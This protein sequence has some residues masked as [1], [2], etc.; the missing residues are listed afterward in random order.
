MRTTTRF[1]GRLREEAKRAAASD[2][3]TLSALIERG[4]RLVLARKPPTPERNRVTLPVSRAQGGL[5]P[6]VD[7]NNS[8]SLY[9]LTDGRRCPS[10]FT[11]WQRYD[12]RR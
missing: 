7:L 12:L 9:D 8:A 4:L 3:E 11:E 6:G 5:L 10:Q 1:D 2:G